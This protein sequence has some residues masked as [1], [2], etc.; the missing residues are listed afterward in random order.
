MITK[1]AYNLF[2]TENW[3]KVI[4]KQDTPETCEQKLKAKWNMLGFEEQN[5]FINAVTRTG[6]TKGMD[7]RITRSKEES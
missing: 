4:S 6:N 7:Q 2:S 3:E 5:K 1:K